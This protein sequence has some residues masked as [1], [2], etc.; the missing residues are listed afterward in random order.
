MHF[1][2]FRQQQQHEHIDALLIHKLAREL[3][4]DHEVP[5]CFAN[6]MFGFEFHRRRLKLEKL[7]ANMLS[8]A[9]ENRF[10][11]S[12]FL[13]FSVVNPNLVFSLSVFLLLVNNEK[14]LI[15]L[16]KLAF[17]LNYILWSVLLL[18]QL[19]E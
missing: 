6:Y 2:R 9:P 10:V 12:V 11:E 1:C 14:W 15:L 8:K 16:L 4:R 7:S 5:D 17:L 18:S 19:I 3:F 13:Y